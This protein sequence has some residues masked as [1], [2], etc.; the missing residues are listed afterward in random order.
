MSIKVDLV[1]DGFQALDSDEKKE[2]ID[3]INHLIRN[4]H[5]IRKSLN[6]G[7][8]RGEIKVVLGPTGETC[9]CCGR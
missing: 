9:P 2:F 1:L 4:P 8:K 5:L 7:I 3:E 6:E